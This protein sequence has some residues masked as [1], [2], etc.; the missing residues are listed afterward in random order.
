MSNQLLNMY[1]LLLKTSVTS[2]LGKQTNRLI[3]SAQK[4]LLV[5]LVFLSS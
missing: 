2:A 4:Q 1:Q 5:A 3:N